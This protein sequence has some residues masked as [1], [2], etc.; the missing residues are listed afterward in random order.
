[1]PRVVSSSEAQN[2][3][4]AMLQWT[5]EQGEEIVV[6]RRGRPAAVIISYDEYTEVVRLRQEERKR[7]ALTAIRQARANVRAANQDL[8]DEEAY[9]L[10]GFSQEVIRETLATDEQLK[11]DKP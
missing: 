8:S 6:E 9:R 10:A 1:M 3:F 5:E 11:A 7:Q 4:G 2:N